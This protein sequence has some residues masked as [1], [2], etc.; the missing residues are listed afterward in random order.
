M[1]KGKVQEYNP[2]RGCGT[3]IDFDSGQQLIVY[4]NYIILKIG[5][6]L[7]KDQNV[8]YDI[9]NKRNEN[10]AVNVEVVP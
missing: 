7:K 3:I 8:E 5:E 6:T 4:A 9:E 1:A 10:W 2:S